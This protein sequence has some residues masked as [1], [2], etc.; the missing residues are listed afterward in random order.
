MSL[1][2]H[3]QVPMPSYLRGAKQ[4]SRIL[5]E[6]LLLGYSSNNKKNESNYANHSCE[7]AGFFGFRPT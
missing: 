1:Y 5:I 3:Y 4:I 6:S 2:F 7:N